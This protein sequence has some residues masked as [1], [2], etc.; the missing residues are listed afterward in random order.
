MDAHISFS[1]EMKLNTVVSKERA[2]DTRVRQSVLDPV[3]QEFNG[4]A[5]SDSALPVCVS[6]R[7]R[8]QKQA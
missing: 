5:E 2:S 6:A 1:L 7:D 8:R 4:G 3:R